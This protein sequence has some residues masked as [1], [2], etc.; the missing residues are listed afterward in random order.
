MQML[1]RRDWEVC[2][3]PIKKGTNE[4]VDHMVKLGLNGITTIQYFE[5]SPDF[6][7]QILQFDQHAS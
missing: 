4:I 3:R 7:L 1:S 5:K 2:F 6:I